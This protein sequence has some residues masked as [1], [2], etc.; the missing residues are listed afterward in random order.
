MD[1][2]CH[3]QWVAANILMPKDKLV[4]LHVRNDYTILSN[5]M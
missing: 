2:V 4:I 3:P 5:G 1:N